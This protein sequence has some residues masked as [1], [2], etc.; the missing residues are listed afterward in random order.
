M[1]TVLVAASL[2]PSSADLDAQ[3]ALA[4]A[5]ASRPKAEVVLPPVKKA[6]PRCVGSCKCEKCQGSPDG[7]PCKTGGFDEKCGMFSCRCLDATAAVPTTQIP[8]SPVRYLSPPASVFPAFSIQPTFLPPFAPAPA[9]GGFGG[10]G[11]P[12]GVCPPG[13]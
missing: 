7:C 11:C 6:T 8:P 1:F 2:I 10:G 3:A 13:G 4:L 12:G 9:F 5:L